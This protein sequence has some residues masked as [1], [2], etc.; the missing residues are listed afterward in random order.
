[1]FSFVLACFGKILSNLIYQAYFLLSKFWT[2]LGRLAQ[3]P[4]VNHFT[5]E[6][7]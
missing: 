7:W 3:Q 1:M 2:Q 4:T 6:L 5:L